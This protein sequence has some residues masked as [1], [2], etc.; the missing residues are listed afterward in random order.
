M[1]KYIQRPGNYEEIFDFEKVLER[2]SAS[3]S[4]AFC[5]ANGLSFSRGKKACGSWEVSADERGR[6]LSG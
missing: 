3:P 2:W 4:S 5:A 6:G 1:G